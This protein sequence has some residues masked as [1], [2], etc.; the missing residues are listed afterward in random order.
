MSYILLP[1]KENTTLELP[2]FPTRMQAVVFRAWE[3]VDARRIAEVLQTT[4]EIVHK[5]AEDM[6]LPAQKNTEQ[7]QERGYITIIKNMW[8]LLPYEQMCQMLGWDEDKLAYTIKEDDVLFVKLGYFKPACEPVLYRPLT[9][10]E[11]QMTRRIKTIIQTRTKKSING[12]EK[13]PFDFVEPIYQKQRKVSVDTNGYDVVLDETWTVNYDG[14]L[15]EV[16][17]AVDLFCENIYA[18]WGIR[19][20]Q[21]KSNGRAIQI[22]LTEADKEYHKVV[23]RQNGIEI[24]AEKAGVLRA[25]MLLLD[26]AEVEGYPCYYEKTYERKATFHTRFLYSYCGLY[27]Q[28]FDFPA[29]RSY[30]EKMLKAYAEAG[31]NGIWTQGV[32]YK[33]VE[34]PYEPSISVGWEKR[35]EN[36]R[37]LVATAQKYGIKVYLYLNEPRSMPL[38]FFDKYPDMKGQVQGDYA[39]ICTSSERGRKYLSDAISRLCREVADLGGFFTITRGENLTNCYSLVGCDESLISNDGINCPR[40]AARKAHEVVAEVDQIIAEAARAVNPNIQII[41]WPWSWSGAYFNSETVEQ[42]IK[43]IPR[44]NAIM[45]VSEHDK[46]LCVGGVKNV[47]RDYSMAHIGPSRYAKNIWEIARQSHHQT[48]AKLQINTTWECSTVPALPVY[49]L[50]IEHLENVKKENVSGVMLG[51]TL[52]GYPSANLKIASGSFFHDVDNEDK[53]PYEEIL[54]SIYQEDYERV[55]KATDLFCQGF[56][57]FPFNHWTLYNAPHNAGVSNL[58]YEKPTG[59]QATMTCFSYDD[60]EGWRQNYPADI[61]EEQYRKIC[62]KWEQGL[63]VISDMEDSEFKDVSIV[64]YSLFKSVYEQIRFIRAR[65]RYLRHD[66]PEIMKSIMCQVAQNELQLAETIYEI[67]RRNPTIGYEAANHYYFNQT[68]ILEK[69]INCNYLIEKYSEGQKAFLS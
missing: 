5:L 57:E 20:E 14:E 62:E 27:G 45:A 40:C 41:S 52:G 30:P 8:H 53:N 35:L 67:M 58:L 69:I 26:K 61:F 9:E 46:E 43:L 68:M 42:G 4:E 49:Q 7:W 60:L 64:G 65:E 1:M 50:I 10:Q 11:K 38:S 17:A 48:F 13:L 51:W 34:F 39:C 33:L 29:E 59:Y 55:K 54:K 44:E 56:K 21:N 24:Y 2:H 25:L 47:V 19:L 16:A 66:E 22:H 32:L 28:A 37:Q 36:L 12:V 18:S 23:I 6:G 31:V 15:Q 63:A 3:M